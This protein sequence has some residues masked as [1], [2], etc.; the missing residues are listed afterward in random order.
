MQT[1]MTAKAASLSFALLCGFAAVTSARAA[2][3]S[4]TGTFAVDN[5]L[6]FFTSL[7]ITSATGGTIGARTFSYS[8]GLNAA[9]NS[10]AAGGFA[11]VLSLFNGMGD[12]VFG[13]VGS[14][15]ACG[16][17]SFCWD[18]FFSFGV[19]AAGSY[20]LV[21]SQDDNNSLGSLAAGFSKD[22]DPNYF[23]GFLG[24]D[25]Q[26]TGNWALDIDITNNSVP[27]SVPEPA[28]LALVTT[29]LG[30]LATI[31]RRRRA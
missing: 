26:R 9:G 10:I 28:G 5:E 4:H 3:V 19:V 30:A 27:S 31:C 23:N 18:A 12:L 21:L 20:T 8:G 1:R 24:Y 6:R 16:G 17:P 13:D 2:P 14:S 29:A 7:N 25:G 11:P 15:H 22:G